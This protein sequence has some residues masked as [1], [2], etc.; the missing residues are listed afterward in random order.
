M[1]RWCRGRELG[2]NGPINNVV[3][4]FRYDTDSGAESA[5]DTPPGA[6]IRARDARDDFD[7]AYAYVEWLGAH[8]G[9][10]GVCFGRRVSTDLLA[11]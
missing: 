7:L 1:R 6:D 3:L 4:P 9:S 10:P 5:R 11:R 8:S 2:W